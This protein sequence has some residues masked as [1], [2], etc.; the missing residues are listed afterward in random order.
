MHIYDE[1]C[2]QVP[3]CETSMLPM[4]ILGRFG[5]VRQQPH[6]ERHP[7]T[8][9][10]TKMELEEVGQKEGKEVVAAIALSQKQE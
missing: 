9:S 3:Q 2:M 7:A 8:V 1:S 10:S 6:Q 4:L 5:K